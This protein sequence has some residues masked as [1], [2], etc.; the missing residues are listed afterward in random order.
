MTLKGFPH[1]D[2]TG[3]KVAS[4]LPDA[5][6]RH[7]TSFIA[8]KSQGIHHAPLITAFYSPPHT[9]QGYESVFRNLDLSCVNAFACNFNAS[10][11][12][13]ASSSDLYAS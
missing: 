4:H 3:S 5:Y 1:S 8:S 12:R 9:Y 10:S 13:L 6:R 2:I 11:L 7:A